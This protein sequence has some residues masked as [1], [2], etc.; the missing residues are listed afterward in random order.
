MR[1]LHVA[2]SLVAELRRAAIDADLRGDGRGV[3]IRFA[4][5]VMAHAG[6]T[7]RERDAAAH[8]SGSVTITVVPCPGGLVRTSDP[9]RASTRST[10]PTSPEPLAAWAPPMPSSVMVADS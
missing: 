9:P 5:G 3:A 7:Q 6:N 10:S 2:A 1:G 8:L 4:A